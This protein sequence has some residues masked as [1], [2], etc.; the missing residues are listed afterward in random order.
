[1]RNDS[2]YII[3]DPADSAVSLAIA[4]RQIV[5]SEEGKAD[6]VEA[7]AGCLG[8]GIQLSEGEIRDLAD[9]R[10]AKEL[11]ASSP[12]ID[13]EAEKSRRAI[14][15]EESISRESIQA[16]VDT[17]L[18]DWIELTPEQNQQL[19]NVVAIN[20]MQG[21][22]MDEGDIEDCAAIIRGLATD[23]NTVRR[24]TQV[25]MS[26]YPKVLPDPLNFIAAQRAVKF[27]RGA[28]GW[29]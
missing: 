24:V 10:A 19:V 25:F 20:H 6:L 17:A 11:V 16:R 21:V 29:K 8:D 5:L 18:G 2:N 12:P 23:M 1:M 14:S 15:I 3:E 7:V 4:G 22:G 28:A 9:V 26:S 13:I 27:G